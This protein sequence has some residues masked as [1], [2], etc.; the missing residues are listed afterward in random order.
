VNMSKYVSKNFVQFESCSITACCI[1]SIA[2]NVEQQE[3]P[4]GVCA[5]CLRMA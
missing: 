1:V 2:G 5:D 4:K 3:C